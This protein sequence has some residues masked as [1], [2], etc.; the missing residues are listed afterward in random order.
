MLIPIRKKQIYC[1]T[2]TFKPPEEIAMN[3]RPI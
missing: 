3:V 1:N 2:A